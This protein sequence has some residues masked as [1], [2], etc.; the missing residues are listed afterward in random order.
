MPTYKYECKKCKYYFEKFQ[1]MFDNPLKKCPKCK[2]EIIRLIDSG[3]GI[4]FKGKGFY[5]TD[6]KDSKCSTTKNTCPKK[7]EDTSKKEN[8]KT[9][10][11][12]CKKKDDCSCCAQ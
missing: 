11:S 4:I 5:K 1:S 3:S 2:G 10:A 9:N 12:E 8:S 6:Y 7:N